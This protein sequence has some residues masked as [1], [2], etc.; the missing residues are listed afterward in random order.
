[1]GV[2]VSGRFLALLEQGL[3]AFIESEFN[4]LEFL[5]RFYRFSRVDLKFR[6]FLNEFVGDF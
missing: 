2:Q 3:L 1:M 5:G 4:Y 6:N